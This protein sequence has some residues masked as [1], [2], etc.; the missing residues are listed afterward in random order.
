MALPGR[1]EGVQLRVE[2]Q[3]PLPSGSQLSYLL[4]EEES[5]NSLALAHLLYWSTLLPEYDS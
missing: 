4:L 1:E 3:S 2:G 5:P